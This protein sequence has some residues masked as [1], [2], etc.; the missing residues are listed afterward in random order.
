MKVALAFLSTAFVATAAQ[1]AEPAAAIDS[2]DLG[3]VPQEISS[4]ITADPSFSAF[5]TLR[6]KINGKELAL[7]SDSSNKTWVATT[8]NGCGWGA[9]MGPIW[10][11]Q[12]VATDKASVILSTGGYVI[13]TSKQ[14]HNGMLDI[15][16]VSG[17]AEL[18]ESK[19][20][21]FSDKAYRLVSTPAIAVDS[22]APPAFR[23]FPA[24]VYSGNLRIP[25]YYVKSDDMWRDDMGKAVAP[26][27]VNFAGKYYIGLHSC[28]TECRYYSL[29]DL[30]TGN[31][32]SALTMFSSAGE[33]PP[34]TSDGRTYVTELLSRPDSKMIVAL[35][36]IDASDN[37][38]EECRERIFLLSDDEQKVSPI[39][40][41]TPSCQPAK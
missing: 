29:S 25:Y 3:P 22:E 21:V 35:Y 39:T 11:A 28:G 9:A 2:K 10:L 30:T 6:C 27:K 20:Y 13:F 5:Q 17:T 19:K 8:A 26:P 4:A 32:S 31:D 37:K 38:P 24:K 7:S 23:N 12:D 34:T 36:H 18:N 41:T 16:I 14:L 1:C 15:F 40:G 33:K